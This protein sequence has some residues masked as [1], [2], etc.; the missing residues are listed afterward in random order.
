MSI[1]EKIYESTLK[2]LV[3]LS[4]E[5]TYKIVVEEA[6]RLVN[7]DSGRIFV[8]SGSDFVPVYNSSSDMPLMDPR[9]K[10]NVYKS[11]SKNKAFIIH[12]GE[13]KGTYPQL[14]NSDIRS[15]MYIPLE[16]R[17]LSYG[18]LVIRSKRDEKFEDSDLQVLK[19]FG[20]LASLAIRKSEL[21]NETKKSLE[22][23]DLFISLAAHELRTPLTTLNGYI[24]LM[25]TR[26]REKKSIQNKW[27]LEL[28]L[29]SQRLKLLIDEFL[30]INRIRSGKLQFNWQ[31]YNLKKI[32]SRSISSFKFNAPM[33]KIVLKDKLGAKNKIIGDPEKLVQVVINILENAHKY[34]SEKEKIL[35]S[36]RYKSPY[37][38]LDIIDQGKGI[39]E[40]DLSRVFEGFY[41]GEGNLHEGMGLGLYLSKN[42]IDAHHGEISIKSKLNKGTKVEIKLPRME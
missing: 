16:N 2:F 36:L 40:Q 7:G 29:E 34:S 10:G 19:L 21:F 20:S 38:V 18:V 6:I 35:V 32:V 39:H 31:E 28:A 22:D 8:K 26:I 41:K 15:I 25:L 23:R 42:I 14:K 24:Q 12:S 1:L 17:N 4:S 9:K 27:V 11:Y 5:E 37:Y 33:R 13:V 3:P 30:E